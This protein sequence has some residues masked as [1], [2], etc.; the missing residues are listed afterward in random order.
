MSTLP[1]AEE[2]LATEPDSPDLINVTRF[3]VIVAVFVG[4]SLV[5]LRTWIGDLMEQPIAPTMTTQR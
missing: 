4:I 1:N 3:I 2:T 5:S